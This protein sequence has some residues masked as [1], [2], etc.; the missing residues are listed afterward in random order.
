M[1]TYLELQEQIKKLQQ[2]ADE[3][4]KAELDNV[5]GELKNKIQQYGLTAK[6]LGLSA[7]AG[8]K[9]AGG[10][11]EVAPKYQKGDETWSGRGRQPK[12]V[13]EHITNGGLL[14]DLL[15]NK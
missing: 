13:A 12:W 4:K 15:I 9:K 14:E 3:L 5:I 6:D 10:R 8:A 1:S 7:P 11:S 2:Q